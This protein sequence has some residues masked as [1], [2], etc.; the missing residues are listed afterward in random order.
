MISVA[1]ATYNGEQFIK[2]QLE[3]ILSQ[4]MPVDEI[5]IVDDQSTDST[6]DVLS[7]FLQNK[8][9]RFYKNEKN[10]GYKRN[11]KKALSYCNG[12]FIFLCDQDDIWKS[13]KVETMVSIMEDKPYIKAL[14]SSFTQID[15]SGHIMEVKQIRG[16][17]N[18]NL[19]RRPVQPDELTKVTFDD[20]C[21]QNYFQGCAL[22]IRKEINDEFQQRFTEDLFH[23]W[24]I[25]LIASKYDGMYFYNHSLFNYRIHSKNTI[26]LNEQNELKGMERMKKTN[27]LYNRLYNAKQSINTLTILLNVDPM[28]ETKQPDVRKKL[29]FYKHHIDNLEQGK[30]FELLISNFSPYYKNVKSYKARVTD[31]YFC[32]KQK[33]N[34]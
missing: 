28:L 31:L 13:E 30:L 20:L 26:G 8:K 33:M 21:I 12:D 19:Y 1:L 24:Q 22:A 27:T 15:E 25:N 6:V 34:H 2:E 3:S 9:I 5:V 17:S 4:S 7:P 11:F 32:L 16:L 14:A 23:D 29:A 10:L 18:N